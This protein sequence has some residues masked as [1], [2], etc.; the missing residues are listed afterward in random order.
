MS[1]KR[2]DFNLDIMMTTM[3]MVMIMVMMMMMMMMM[4]LTDDDGDDDDDDDDNKASKP[5]DFRTHLINSSITMVLSWR[6]MVQPC[7]R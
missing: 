3:V 6:S 5:I 1:A 2:G 4:I 7:R